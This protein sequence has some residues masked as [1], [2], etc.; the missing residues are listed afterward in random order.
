MFVF[1]I[2]YHYFKVRRS[3]CYALQML[4]AICAD[5]A[6]EAV[7]RVMD[8]LNDDSLVVR[9]QALETLH[10]MNMHSHPKVEESHLHM[11]SL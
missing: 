1:V 9:L 8:L 11:V 5:F 6:S 7:H 2:S 10:Y 3:A 4:T